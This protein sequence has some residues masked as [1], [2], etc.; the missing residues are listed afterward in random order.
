MI[1]LLFSSC[2]GSE[3]S[4]SNTNPKEQLVNIL[5]IQNT[6]FCADENNAD[7]LIA[8]RKAAGEWE[9]FTIIY[10]NPNTIVL[11]SFKNKY[12]TVD[13]GKSKYLIANSESI[14]QAE[15]FV[16][17]NQDSGYVA[18]K[19]STG[20]YLCSDQIF[21]GKLVANRQAIGDWEKFRIVELVK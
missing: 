2:G 5:A 19:S 13:H 3:S 12:V 10:L 16:L 17:M 7:T 20:D 15:Q 6:F 18:F 9:R 8:N 21:E 4:K 14:D 1:L 11:K